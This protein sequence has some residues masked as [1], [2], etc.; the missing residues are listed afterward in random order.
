[1]RKYSVNSY[2]I[3]TKRGINAKLVMISDLHDNT[4][5]INLEKAFE[6][7]V[8]INPEFVLV[9]GDMYTGKP[10]YLNENAEKFMEKLSAEFK[11]IYGLGNHEHRMMIEP[12]KYPGMYES[13][14]KM[15]DRTGIILLKNE[16]LD[17]ELGCGKTIRITG[18]MMDH[19]FYKKFKRPNMDA[20]YIEGELGKKSDLYTI[21]IAHHPIYFDNYAKWGA[22]LIVS[23]HMHGGMARLPVIG[24]IIG[25]DYRLFPKFDKG[26]FE[27]ADSTLILSAGMG[28]HTI[29]IR[30]F[31]LPEIVVIDLQ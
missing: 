10:G 4:Y 13:F 22:E 19:K 15:I 11:V 1:M 12:E 7:I 5:G 29:N 31:N 20:G 27:Q 25:S 8:R 9:A 28:T 14:M 6:D 30:P 26:R 18:L 2:K 23:G 21:L 24:G 16:S 3:D 17:V